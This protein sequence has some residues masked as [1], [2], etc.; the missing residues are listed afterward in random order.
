MAIG[1]AHVPPPGWHR[2]VVSLDAVSRTMCLYL[3]GLQY[4]TQTSLGAWN[5][6]ASGALYLG[7]SPGGGNVPAGVLADVIYD[8]GHA[9]TAAQAASDYFDATPPATYSHRWPLDDGAGT[10]ARATRGGLALTLSGGAVFSGDSPMIGRGTYRNF[11]SSSDDWTSTRWTK[12]G[13]TP[14]A[15][16]LTATATTAT[17]FQSV[18]PTG[19]VLCLSYYV[20]K[21]YSFTI[22]ADDQVAHGAGVTF[23]GTTGAYAGAS[24]VGSA[25]KVLAYGC[26]DAGAY[27]LAYVTIAHPPSNAMS[28]GIALNRNKLLAWGWAGG[29][30]VSDVLTAYAAQ[31]EDAYPGQTSPSAPLST[32]LAPLSVYGAREWRQNLA[33]SSEDMSSAVYTSATGLTVLA[34]LPGVHGLTSATKLT[35]TNAVA[36]RYQDYTG[37]PSL[38]GDVYCGSAWLW[39]DTPGKQIGLRLASLSAGSALQVKTITLTTTPTRYFVTGAC[40]S[41]T[42]KSGITFG[43]DNR[44]SAGGADGATGTIFVDG[45]QL[46]QASDPGAYIR[47]TSAIANSSGA[48]RSKAA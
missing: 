17:C 48:P 12:A 18:S 31:L 5:L 7:A 19:S 27:W 41:P 22:K 28:V 14:T 43:L 10:T 38:V 36:Y 37:K 21:G 46:E 1:F 23:D 2:L 13:C 45:V 3:D 44:S 29:A 40:I 24:S 47:T 35:V 25:Y 20:L 8:V 26:A 30:V 6:D 9:W 33:R 34:G 15:S 16:T 32:G 39:T 11:L 4:E 42:E